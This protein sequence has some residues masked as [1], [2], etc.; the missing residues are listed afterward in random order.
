MLTDRRPNI[1]PYTY[2]QAYEFLKKQESVFWNAH[3]IK[4]ERDVNQ[5]YNEFTPAER[6]LISTL[7]KIFT[8]YELHIGCYWSDVVARDFGGHWEIGAMAKMFSAMENVHAVFYNKLNEGLGLNTP[9][10]YN[11]WTEDKNLK[12]NIEVIDKYFERDHAT[13]LAALAFTEGVKLYGSF[14]VLLNFP[15]HGKLRGVENGL[16]YSVFD[17]TLHCNASSWLYQTYCSEFPQ[18]KLSPDRVQNMAET[19]VNAECLLIDR[20]FDKGPIEGIKIADVKQFVKN[21]ANRVVSMLGYDK[22]YPEAK[23]EI[24]EWFYLMINAKEDVDFF[25]SKVTDYTKGWDFS[26]VQ[27]W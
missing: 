19:F 2:P 22:P 5:Y 20:L 7:L 13:G 26:G 1:Q 9:E 24:D 15:R 11:S 27:K 25:V 12:A 6:H 14:A 16:R 4:T 3:E 18:Y 23:S 21:R 8:E 17:E 10:F